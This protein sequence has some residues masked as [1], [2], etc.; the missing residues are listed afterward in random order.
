[1]ISPGAAHSPGPNRTSRP[2]WMEGPHKGTISTRARSAPLANDTTSLLRVAARQIF[3]GSVGFYAVRMF[4][5]PKHGGVQH[6]ISEPASLFFREAT[7]TWL[8]PSRLSTSP[9]SI[10]AYSGCMSW[11]CQTRDED[12][13]S[14]RGG[15]CVPCQDSR[16]RNGTWST[17]RVPSTI[18]RLQ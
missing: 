8:I 6:R 10:E 7:S 1:M 17:G 16:V 14:R 15:Q 12:N 11:P 4:L 13:K 5:Q 3:F 18:N 2:H 9:S